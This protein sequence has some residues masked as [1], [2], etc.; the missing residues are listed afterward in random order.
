MNTLRRSF[1]FLLLVLLVFVLIAFTPL[2]ADRGKQ[3]PQ[4][5][6]APKA[7]VQV[8]SPITAGRRVEVK[9]RGAT[10]SGLLDQDLPAT[11]TGWIVV[12]QDARRV[13]LPIV[14]VDSVK[15]L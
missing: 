13:V 14:N 2:G 7:Q 15:E 8:Q 1:P 6:P 12:V 9:V 11:A 3:D 4:T 10:Y 5:A